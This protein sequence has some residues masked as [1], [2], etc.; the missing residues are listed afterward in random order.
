MSTI[1]R[2]KGLAVALLIV[3]PVPAWAIGT[4]TDGD[5]SFGYT[6]NFN[7]SFNTPFPDTVD[8]DFTGAAAGDLTWESWWFF[9]VSGGLYETAFG[10][11]DAED[12]TLFGGSVGQLD[13]VDPGGAGL[14]SAALGF[15]AIDTGVDQGVLFQNMQIANTSGAALTI[16]IFHYTDLDLATSFG[17][18]SASI[19]PNVDGIEI[20]VTDGVNFSQI[21]GYGADQFQ[22]TAY[23]ALLQDL[24]D[25]NLDN[26]DGSGDGFGPGDFT[27]AF[28]W[29]ANLGVGESRDFLTQ[30]G[31]D[32]ALLPA[33]VSQVPEPTAALLTGLGLMALARRARPGRC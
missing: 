33:S 23:A 11:P 4:V 10:T 14:F 5:V 7:T 29:S 9:R 30:F 6:Q 25:N 18:D 27:G 2:W 13:W 17:G 12:Y 28:Q 32:A 8:T 24:T 31:S 22:I 20:S 3:C 19:I 15:E 26:L 21:I 1:T 16:D